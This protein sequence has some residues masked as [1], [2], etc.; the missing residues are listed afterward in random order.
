M[1]ELNAVQTCLLFYS[2]F[3]AGVAALALGAELK[4]TLA[5]LKR[6][7]KI[8]HATYT[9][10]Q[11]ECRKTKRLEYELSELRTAAIKFTSVKTENGE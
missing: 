10:W 11:E 8:E 2:S 4:R 3:G 5:R 1:I 6:I 9:A 7:E